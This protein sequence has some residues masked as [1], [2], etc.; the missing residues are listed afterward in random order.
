MKVLDFLLMIS[1]E[2]L[3]IMKNNCFLIIKSKI[4]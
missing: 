1:K 2:L 4:L 3:T